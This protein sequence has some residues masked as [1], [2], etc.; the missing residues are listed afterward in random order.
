MAPRRMLQIAIETLPKHVVAGL[1]GEHCGTAL[2]E[3]IATVVEHE[4]AVAH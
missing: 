3:R 4:L 2:T 1:R